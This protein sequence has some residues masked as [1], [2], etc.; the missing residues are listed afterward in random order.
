MKKIGIIVLLSAII[1]NA[2][3]QNVSAEKQ[4][5]KKQDSSVNK[6][7]NTKVIVGKD[8]IKIEEGDS[9]VNVRVGNRGLNILESLE[10]N[11]YRF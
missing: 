8:L 10:G 7:E 5:E 11:K 3:S 9:S 6:I 1:M 4:N 2:F